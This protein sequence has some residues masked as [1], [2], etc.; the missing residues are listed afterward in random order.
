M[1]LN[2]AQIYTWHTES[3]FISLTGFSLLICKIT[4]VVRS[5]LWHGWLAI[6]CLPNNRVIIHFISRSNRRLSSSEPQKPPFQP[7]CGPLAFQHSFSPLEGLL[8]PSALGSPKTR[9][10]LSHL[11]QISLYPHLWPFKLLILFSGVM[12]LKLVYK[13]ED[14]GIE[15]TPCEYDFLLKSI[16]T[17]ILSVPASE[18]GCG[19]TS[20]TNFGLLVSEPVLTES[21]SISAPPSHM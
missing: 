13:C 12:R 10:I 3:T 14:L 7:A 4:W 11:L 16:F 1:K 5:G 19:P 2:V 18:L 6:Y 21:Q 8:P 9:A 15:S 20:P 17:H